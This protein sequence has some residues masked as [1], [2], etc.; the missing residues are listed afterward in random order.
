MKDFTSYHLGLKHIDRQTVLE[1]HE[2]AVAM[3]LFTVQLDQICI[4]MDNNYLYF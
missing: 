1:H 2:T 3:E 4:V